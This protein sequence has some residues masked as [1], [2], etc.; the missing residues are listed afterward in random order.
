MLAPNL[1]ILLLTTLLDFQC[2]DLPKS[3]P[4]PSALNA[5]LMPTGQYSHKYSSG[6]LE[7]DR[8]CRVLD[9]CS[10]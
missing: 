5:E 9:K 7:A 8:P 4:I 2:D 10:S 6:L 3:L 1:Y